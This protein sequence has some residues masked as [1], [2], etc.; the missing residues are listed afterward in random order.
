MAS[1]STFL[2]PGMN[3]TVAPRPGTETQPVSP[4]KTDF[5]NWVRLRAALEGAPTF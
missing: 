3:L 1:G 2:L 4:D 5:S